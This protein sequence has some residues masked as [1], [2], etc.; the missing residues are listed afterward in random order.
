MLLLH[1]TRPG[2]EAPPVALFGV[3]LVGSAIAR[4]LEAG[5]YRGERLAFP[6]GDPGTWRPRLE[7]VSARLAGVGGLAVVWSA[8]RAGF[9]SGA[10][11]C[12][13]E[14][15]V[16]GAVLAMAGGLGARVDFHLVSSFGGLFEG[17]RVVGRGSA[18]RP[19]RPYGELKLRQEERLAAATG[20]ARRV[21]Y[22]MSSVYGPAPAGQRRG[23][24]PSLVADACARRVSHIGGRPSTLRDYL[25]AGDA[26]RFVARQV[27]ERRGDAVHLLGSG[28]PSSIGEIVQRV[29]SALGR[30]LYLQY[31]TSPGNPRDISLAPSALPAG[32]VPRHLETVVRQLA[33]ERLPL[34][35][36]A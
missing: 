4:A 34:G 14:E 22:R 6:W 20:L 31:S 32:F 8:G 11:E 24:I 30:R 18:P 13:A 29:E 19:R 7:A 15:Q 16:F 36:G 3:G 27:R 35:H 17:Q 10:G 33:R 21:V 5:G 12:A 28:K 25:W 9:A 1:P 23:L 2:P 26:G